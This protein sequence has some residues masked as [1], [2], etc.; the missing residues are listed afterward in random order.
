MSSALQVNV[1][2][3]EQLKN[4]LRLIANDKSKRREVLLILRQIAKPTLETAK[5][6]APVSKKTH[7]AHNQKITPGNLKKSL[8]TIT[9]KNKENPTILV[10][11]RVKGSFKGWY[12]HF[13]HEGVNVY[14]KGFKRKHKK[15]VNNSSAVRRTKSNPFLTRAYQQTEGKVT[16]DAEA[17]FVK[18]VQ[19]RLN[20]LQ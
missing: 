5:R 13:V 16:A 1:Q 4:K 10:G 9:G 20:K 19:R 12:G 14:N 15:G 6:M 11:P 3:Y 17:K 2:G 7:L 18:F 8:G